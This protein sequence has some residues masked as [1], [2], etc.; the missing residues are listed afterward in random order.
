MHVDANKRFVAEFLPKRRSEGSKAQPAT[1][2]RKSCNDSDDDSNKK[3]RKSCNDSDDESNKKVR[4]SSE[5]NDS[6]DDS[7]KK[8]LERLSNGKFF[9]KIA[10]E[11][12]GSD[13]I[14][15]KELNQADG[16]CLRKPE[17]SSLRFRFYELQLKKFSNKICDLMNFNRRSFRTFYCN[18]INF[19][20]KSFRT[21]FIIL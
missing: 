2:V 8:V 17:C 6:D 3:V 12:G 10:K 20:R 4:K 21:N 7:N 11:A 5:A 18:F 13:L 1:K 19:S 14:R 9:E 15:L 16:G